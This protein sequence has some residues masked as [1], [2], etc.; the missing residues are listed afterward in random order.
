MS[1]R[2]LSGDE[3]SNQRVIKGK[4]VKKGMSWQSEQRRE[5]RGQEREQRNTCSSLLGDLTRHRYVAL[6]K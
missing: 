3:R 1:R 6:S 5:L 4:D 2:W